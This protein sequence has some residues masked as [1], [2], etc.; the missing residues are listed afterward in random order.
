MW[1]EVVRVSYTS[2][3]CIM[4]LVSAVWE[5]EYYPFSSC[6]CRCLLQFS[7]KDGCYYTKPLA[8]Y[9]NPSCRSVNHEP[10]SSGLSD[11]QI[12]LPFYIHH[13]SK[14]V[15]NG[16]KQR[17]RIRHLNP[18]EYQIKLEQESQLKTFL[19][20]DARERNWW[21]EWPLSSCKERG[22]ERHSSCGRQFTV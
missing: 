17:W 12:S 3:F 16:Y 13:L 11:A 20:W 18:H 6:L 19:S 8:L 9:A 15:G 5:E 1:L 4:S 7:F 21:L 2:V 10:S 14:D 22:F